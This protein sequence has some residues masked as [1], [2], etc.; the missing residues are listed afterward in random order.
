MPGPAGSRTVA[1]WHP[2]SATRS[3]LRNTTSHDG[4][5]R[6]RLTGGALPSKVYPMFPSKI[7]GAIAYAFG[8]VTPMSKGK[9]LVVMSSAKSL[10]LKDGKAYSTGYYLNEF[11]VP[12]RKL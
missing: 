11:V 10:D 8:K 6:R 1:P 12:Y 2:S 7:G 9:V 3:P 4:R 5:L